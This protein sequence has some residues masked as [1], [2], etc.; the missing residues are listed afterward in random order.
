MP[1]D[2]ARR[3]AHNDWNHNVKT[4]PPKLSVPAGMI[5]GDTLNRLRNHDGSRINE[6][7]GMK[8]PFMPATTMS[9][10]PRYAPKPR[11]RSYQPRARSAIPNHLRHRAQP[12]VAS[13]TLSPT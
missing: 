13:R 11:P 3:Y 8:K 7:P 12:T 9:S 4:P 2:L 6:V 1:P 10:K 5:K